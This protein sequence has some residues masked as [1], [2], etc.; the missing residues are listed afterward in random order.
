MKNYFIR[1]VFGLL[2]IGILVLFSEIFKVEIFNTNYYIIALF[3]GIAGGWLGWFFYKLK[4]KKSKMD[5]EIFMNSILIKI[6]NSFFRNRV[7]KIAVL[8]LLLMI[9]LLLYFIYSLNS[10]SVNYFYNGLFQILVACINLLFCIEQYILKK[11]GSSIM[12]LILAI[13]F[14]YTGI[15][16]FNLYNL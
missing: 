1:L 7:K 16:S 10:E 9:P 13:V 5:R 6:S 4:K 2:T 11:K 15:Q 8:Q 12:F 14:V 3:I